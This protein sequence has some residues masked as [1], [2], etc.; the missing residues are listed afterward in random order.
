[1]RLPGVEPGVI[2][3]DGKPLIQLTVPSLRGQ[4]LLLKRFFDLLG[5]L[6]GIV[7]FSPVFALVAL[8]VK[9]DSPGP[10]FFRQT[11]VG[12]GGRPFRIAKFRT[13]RVGA[14]EE[15]NDLRQQSVYT[16]G[17]LFKV[18]GDPRVTRV[19]RFLRRS[20]LDELPQL[21]N[22]LCGEMSLVGPRPP[23]PSEVDLYEEQHYAR[24][25][26]KPG[27]TGPWQ[28]SGRNNI[29]SFED[30]VKLETQYIREWNLAS[31][32][33]ILAKTVGVVLGMRGAH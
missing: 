21:L 5:A 22:V 9:L 28:V 25:D 13:M 6:A 3:R 29:E 30:V 27:M 16:D 20:S 17:R 11:R 26:V 15:L 23:L 33:V 19:G 14:E 32:L 24:F 7:L 4:Q 1:V 31:D 18:R 10:A 8:I 12:R 2:W